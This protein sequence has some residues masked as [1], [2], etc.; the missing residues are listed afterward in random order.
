[1]MSFPLDSVLLTVVMINGKSIDIPIKIRR[2][3]QSSNTAAGFVDSG[4]GVGL[5]NPSRKY[6]D[7]VAGCRASA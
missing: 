7:Y 3:A 6:L 2:K 5:L 1:M 4:M